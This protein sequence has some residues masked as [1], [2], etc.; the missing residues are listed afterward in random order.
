MSQETFLA[1]VY[2]AQQHLLNI[3]FR[4]DYDFSQ[5]LL[6]GIAAGMTVRFIHKFIRWVN[7]AQFGS[8]D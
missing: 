3:F 7:A 8:D 6:A 4:G 5:L 1:G 2:E